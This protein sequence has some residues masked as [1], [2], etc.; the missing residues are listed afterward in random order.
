IARCEFP[1]AQAPVEV[2]VV[3]LHQPERRIGPGNVLAAEPAQSFI[4][5]TVFAGKEVGRLDVTAGEIEIA[6]VFAADN[7]IV[8]EGPVVFRLQREGTVDEE[9]FSAI[10]RGRVGAKSAGAHPGV[11]VAGGRSETTEGGGDAFPLAESL[12]CS[13]Y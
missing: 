3:I 13:G 2:A 7:G 6:A 11:F 1:G 9:H 8:D 4:I 5:G 12:G 10:D